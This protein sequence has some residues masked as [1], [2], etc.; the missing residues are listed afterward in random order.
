YDTKSFKTEQK[1]L[2]D[3]SQRQ[4][5]DRYFLAKSHENPVKRIHGGRH[6]GM[7]NE[8]ENRILQTANSIQRLKIKVKG[9]TGIHIGDMINIILRSSKASK[10]PVSEPYSGY[11]LVSKVTHVI[12]FREKTHVTNLELSR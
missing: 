10:S 11:W 4:I 12:N 9:N 1:V 3:S 8:V 7:A 2:S 5:S 6:T